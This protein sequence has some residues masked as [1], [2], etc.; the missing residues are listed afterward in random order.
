MWP[1]IKKIALEPD[2]LL[3][4]CMHVIDGESYLWYPVV[5]FPALPLLCRPTYQCYFELG[6][7]NSIAHVLENLHVE[8]CEMFANHRSKGIIAFL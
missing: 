2:F 8:Y 6:D 3:K 5:N 1:K 7:P 4:T